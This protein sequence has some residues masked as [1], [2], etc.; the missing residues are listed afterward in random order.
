MLVTDVR[1]VCLLKLLSCPFVIRTWMKSPP[2]EHL[3]QLLVCLN[4]FLRD[5]VY[6]TQ[7]EE[8]AGIPAL[9]Q[10]QSQITATDTQWLPF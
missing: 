6:Q 5:P 1:S 7:F 4:I 8:M 10:V 3:Y 9:A 2:A